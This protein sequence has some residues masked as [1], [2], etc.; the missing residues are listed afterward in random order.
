MEKSELD[1]GFNF[2]DLLNCE[3][4]A[5]DENFT[6][7]ARMGDKIIKV[8]KY[9]GNFDYDI[10][11][12]YKVLKFQNIVKIFKC[13][14]NKDY[15]ITI[16]EKLE[17]IGN[18]FKSYEESL[19]FLRSCV[20]ALAWLQE[21][22]I[23]HNDI[24]IDNI[25]RSKSGIYK[26]IDF[27]YMKI[28]CKDKKYSNENSFLYCGTKGYMSPERCDISISGINAYKCD[29][30]SLGVTFLT[31]IHNTISNSI[32]SSNQPVGPYHF[33][34]CLDSLTGEFSRFREIIE[35]MIHYD[36]NVRLDFIQLSELL[37]S[38]FKIIE[39][40]NANCEACGKICDE[41]NL[42]IIENRCL[43]C[44]ECLRYLYTDLNLYLICRMNGICL[45]CK[46]QTQGVRVLGC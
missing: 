39:V 6:D 23:S 31:M 1:I 45:I 2:E 14:K 36:T 33:S 28:D 11:E 29:V 20:V 16:M 43:I 24:K 10:C 27:D 4:I 30:Y 41:T 12:N 7:V 13:F 15:M 26:I 40:F 44:R 25:M 18:S 5:G 38:K 3:H 21:K 42:L 17:P 34:Q 22:N 32:Y 37:H 19:H 9:K 8:V 35:L 46:S